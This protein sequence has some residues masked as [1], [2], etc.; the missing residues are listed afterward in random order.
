METPTVNFRHPSFDH[1]TL[2]TLHNGYTL[3]VRYRFACNRY[4]RCVVQY[5]P[6]VVSAL[7]H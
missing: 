3:I 1:W 4:I 2:N 5:C 6:V 7:P